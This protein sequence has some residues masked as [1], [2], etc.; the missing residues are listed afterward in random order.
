MTSNHPLISK[1]FQTKLFNNAFDDLFYVNG[2]GNST[3]DEGILTYILKNNSM[4]PAKGGSIQGIR[5]WSDTTYFSHVINGMAIAGRVMEN[6]IG[7]VSSDSANT[8]KTEEYVRLFFAS[9]ALHDVDK[10]FGEGY[11]GAMALDKVLERHKQEIIKICSY[12]LHDLGDA[13]NWWGDLSYLILR[14]ENRT[15]EMAN[16]LTTIRE[17]TLLSTISDFT[18]LADQTGGIKAHTSNDIF[19][20]M[21]KLLNK[22]GEKASILRFSRMSQ[23]LLM[24]KLLETARETI[25]ELGRYIIAETP[26]G[27]IYSGEKLSRE[28]MLKVKNNFIEKVGSLDGNAVNDILESYAPSNNS[29]KLEFAIDI[30]PTLD[31]VKLYVE[32]FGGRLLLWSG[33]EWKQTHSDFDIKSRKFD[34]PIYSRKIGDDISFFMETPEKSEE[35]EDSENM[36]RRILGLMA[37]AR[38]VYY[39]CFGNKMPNHSEEMEFL[40]RNFGQEYEANT[41]ERSNQ[42]SVDQIQMKTLLAISYASMFHN[43]TYKELIAKYQETLKSLSEELAIQFPSQQFPDY[44]GFFENSIGMINPTKVPDKSNMCIQCGKVGD[45]PLKD[46]YAFGYKATAGGGLKISVLKYDEVRFNGKICL[47][48]AKENSMRRSEIGKESEALCVRIN[49]A[50]YVVPLN[51]KRMIDSF[52]RNASNRKGYTIEYGDDMESATIYLG[53]RS[54]KQLEYHTVM[55]VSKPK[56]TKEAFFMLYGLVRLVGSRGLKVKVTPLF[57]SE[58]MFVPM[59]T[60]ENAPYWVRSLGMAEIR[61]DRIHDSIRELDLIY[62][63][64]KLNYGYDGVFNFVIENMTRS[65]MGLLYAA[66]RNILSDGPE[67]IRTKIKSIKEE[68][69]WYMEKYGNELKTGQMQKIVNEA[70]GIIMGGPKSGNDHTW[71]IRTALDAYSRNIRKEDGELEGIISGR[72]WEIAKRDK[73][74]GK[75]VQDHAVM[76]SKLLVEML[77]NDFKSRIPAYE[78]R[79]DIVAEFAI[80]YNITKWNNIK[81]PK[82]MKENE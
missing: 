45:F 75:D 80:L 47:M 70:C 13:R 41:D 82:E 78:Y 33:Q 46:Q 26:N 34:I 72:I 5:E 20:E 48:C 23:S 66:W 69:M 30:P 27:I 38:R 43:L 53:T 16:V 31:T 1:L 15:M 21:N 10:L 67:K 54:K 64:S 22:F 25:V 61:I 77:R 37:C 50:D 58:D 56:K 59:F 17:K 35:I 49:L 76:F 18:K 74:Y 14:T 8:K 6:R 65:R 36:R 51:L 73:Y 4:S 9:V 40:V 60:W 12:Y 62:N 44:N 42:G 29:I 39:Q 24:A 79:K 32:K 19:L 81:K 55:F 11:D 7:K 71:M 28:E 63:V 52:G 57:S 68:V 3:M 2:Q